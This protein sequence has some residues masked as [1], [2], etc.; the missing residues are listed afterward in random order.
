MFNIS[1]KFV[2]IK[3]YIC[4]RTPQL[5][6]DRSSNSVLSD[7]KRSCGEEREKRVDSAVV[8]ELRTAIRVIVESASLVKTGHH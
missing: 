8:A 1:S 7:T 5:L 2:L 3:S 6:K 4:Q